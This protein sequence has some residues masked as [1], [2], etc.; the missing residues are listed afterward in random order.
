MYAGDR[1]L[2]Q[3]LKKTFKIKQN[4]V[5]EWPDKKS[6]IHVL[7]TFV[8]GRDRIITWRALDAR[9]FSRNKCERLRAPI[10]NGPDLASQKRYP[11]SFVA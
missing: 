6:E 9:Y 3:I 2:L 1:L 8:F 11:L 5:R 7:R 10:R 4:M